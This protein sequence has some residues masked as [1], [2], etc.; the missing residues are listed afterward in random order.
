MEGGQAEVH[1]ALARALRRSH[2]IG[3]G[4]VAGLIVEAGRE[5][6]LGAVEIRL[7]DVQQRRLVSLTGG[8]ALDIDASLAG[9]AYRTQQVQRESGGDRGSWIPMADGIERLGVLY[10]APDGA[11]D[12]AEATERG[13][14]LATLGALLVVSKSTHDDGLVTVVRSRPM[15]HQAELLWAFLPPRTIGSG[16]VTSSA[17][18]EPAYDVGGDA[19]DHSFDG[20][21]LQLAV[22]DA[23][24]HDLAAGGAS[25]IAL[26]AFRAARRDGTR[27]SGG[28][29]VAALAGVALR[30]EE[31]LL[32][33][34]PDRLLTG[35][36]A[37]LD[38]V[39]GQLTWVNC[40]HPPPLLIRDG[41]VVPRALERTAQLPLGL[42]AYGEGREPRGH[43]VRLQPGDRVLVHSDGVTEARSPD[44]ETFGEQRLTDFVVR[45]MAAGQDA[46][47]A[48][49]RLVLSL[50]DHRAHELR[51]DA[52]ILLT[53]WHPP[54]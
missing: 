51:D 26:A 2:G 48:L 19:F 35:V 29:G 27:V 7:S 9:L 43:T 46:P 14:A 24:G 13:E 20:D 36:L 32:R 53:E 33:W 44:G 50:I 31:A 47:E 41:H 45:S 12:P 8:A 40:G 54:H 6:G 34:I 10:A 28:S 25:S 52:T 39:T 5:L 1:G 37:R 21:V 30:I 15:S 4:E 17:V 18:L 22:L 11:A 49:R 16:R 38:T 3:P 23:M 42:G